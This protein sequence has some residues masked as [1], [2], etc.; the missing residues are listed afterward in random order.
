VADKAGF[1]WEGRLRCSHGYGG[2]PE[3]DRFLWARPAEDPAPSFS[4]RS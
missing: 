2:G 1:T 4:S 3:V